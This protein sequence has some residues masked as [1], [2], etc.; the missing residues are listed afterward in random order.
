MCRRASGAAFVTWF[1]VKAD[2][3]QLLRGEPTRFA[4]SARATRSFCAQCGTPL[5]FQL[6]RGPA[7][8]DITVCSLDHPEALM[9]EDHTWVGD[10][11]SWIGLSDG[12]PQHVRAREG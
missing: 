8:L 5:T 7:E 11:L 3:F 1:S 6:V 12:L 4:S 2:E 9:P 10:R